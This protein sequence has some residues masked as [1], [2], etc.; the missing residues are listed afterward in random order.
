MQNSRRSG[1]RSAQLHDVTEDD[2]RICVPPQQNLFE[3]YYLARK[4]M[5]NSQQSFG[6]KIPRRILEFAEGKDR[7]INSRTYRRHPKVTTA[8]S[9]RPRTL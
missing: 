1:P 3:R 4:H 2:L 6:A 9:E 8:A 5:L 7:G